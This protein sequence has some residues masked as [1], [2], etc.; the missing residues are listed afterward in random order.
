MRRVAG[1]EATGREVTEC[2]WGWG[3]RGAQ[4][5]IQ[6][7]TR[8]YWWEAK[9]KAVKMFVQVN[10]NNQKSREGNAAVVQTQ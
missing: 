7:A 9:P 4:R 6:S 5:N 10:T 2:W 1:K 8:Y 3:V